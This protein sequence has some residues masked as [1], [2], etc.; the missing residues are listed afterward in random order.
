MFHCKYS[1]E[2]RG[3]WRVFSA[4]LPR[5]FCGIGM[6]RQHLMRTN[7]KTTQ[8]LTAC[9]SK[10]LIQHTDLKFL[11]SSFI[12][13]RD[14]LARYLNDLFKLRIKLT[15]A[16]HTGTEGIDFSTI[17]HMSPI[18]LQLLAAGGDCCVHKPIVKCPNAGSECEKVSSELQSHLDFLFEIACFEKTLIC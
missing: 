8:S 1:F 9:L 5:T 11:N 14:S 2:F 10:H 15:I 13:L 16:T 6:Q 18:I 4:D 12:D 3:Q 7:C 17:S